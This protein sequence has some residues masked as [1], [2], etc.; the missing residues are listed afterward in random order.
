MANPKAVK[1]W[2]LMPWVKFKDIVYNIY[3]HRIQ[4]AHEVNGS[5][6]MSYCALNEYVLIYFMD[7]YRERPKVEDKLVEL[8]INLRYF[9]DQQVRAKLFAQ[10][11]ELIFMRPSEIVLAG[12]KK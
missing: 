9:Y 11:M 8:F 7:V 2:N 4:H 10:N 1:T 6:N 12:Q 5:A 3:E